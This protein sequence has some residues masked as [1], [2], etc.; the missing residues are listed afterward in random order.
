MSDFTTI[1]FLKLWI[2]VH[3]FADWD[4]EDDFTRGTYGLVFFLNAKNPNTFPKSIALKTLDPEDLP[5]TPKALD[6]LQ[7]EFAM[8]LRLSLGNSGIVPTT[9]MKEILGQN[10]TPWMAD[11]LVAWLLL[12]SDVDIL[13]TDN[14]GSEY[15]VGRNARW[16]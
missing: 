11:R 15:S 14:T 2:S 5:K 4:L 8:W 12:L 10:R 16:V 9:G 1:E 6:E 13:E 3:G 7:R